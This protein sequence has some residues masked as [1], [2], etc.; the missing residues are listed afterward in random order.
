MDDAGVYQISNE[1]AL[2]QT[3]DF[4]SPI[5]NSP[6]D[7]GQIVAANSLSDIYAMGGSPCTAMNVLAYP[8]GIIPKESIA[9][10]LTGACEKLKEAGVALV[11]G[12]TME[13]EEFF[14]GMSITG[15]VHPKQFTT[16]SS[17]RVGDVIILTKA[18]GAGPY[19]DALA[20]DELTKEQYSQF[21][22]MMSRLNKYASETM[23]EFDVSAMTDVTGFGLLGHS[24][25]IAKNANVVLSY[26][27]EHI[28]FLDDIVKIMEKF[29]TKGVCKNHE[30]VEEYLFV[31]NRVDE[32]K[33]KLITEAQT[34]GGLLIIIKR[35]EAKMALEKLHQCGDVSSKII[36]EVK[37]KEDNNIFLEVK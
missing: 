25:A 16:N 31:E 5:V 9:E 17:A 12:H 37:K 18:L 36:G 11:G 14:Y 33:M 7:F 1:I 19:S 26:D 3:V 4:F 29:N 6:Y 23:S 32:Q 10:L 13:Q 30:Y 15:T 27:I 21:F 28:P 24:L 8:A 22:N 35:E 2:V 34:S 20:N